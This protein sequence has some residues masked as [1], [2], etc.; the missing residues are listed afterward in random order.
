M[1]DNAN[2][3]VAG[4]ENPA[5]INVEAAFEDYLKRQAN[6]AGGEGEEE[7]RA[8]EAEAKTGQSEGDAKPT[9][10]E[11]TETDEQRFKVK[12]NGEE[13]EIPLSELVKGY[14]LEA[15]YRIKTSQVAEQSRAAQAQ[16]QQAQALQTQYAEALTAYSQQLQSMRPQPADASLIDSDPV[17]YLRQQQAYQNWHMQMQQVQQ[18]QAQLSDRQQ[19]EQE[20]HT[21][22]LMATEAD[23]LTKAIPDWADEGKAKAGKAELAKYLQE[24]VGF[25]KERIAAVADHRAIVMARKA[26]LYDQLMSKQAAAT[27]KVA[28]LPPKA[29]QRPGGGEISPTDGRTRAIQSLKKTGSIDDAANAFAAYLSR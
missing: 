6:P 16:F 5:P 2:P 9:D 19:Q 27:D 26:M 11:P 3:E 4:S 8:A 29:P 1:E 23:L 13:R 22:S 12:I 17:G 28:K 15:D 7:Q 20:A 24:V 25:D 21:R 10:P 18:E 14:Q